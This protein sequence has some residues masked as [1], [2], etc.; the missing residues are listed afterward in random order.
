ML[1]QFVRTLLSPS[2]KFGN[3]TALP[4]WYS[5]AISKAKSHQGVSL[6]LVFVSSERWACSF[7]A[8]RSLMLPSRILPPLLPN[9]L[10]PSNDALT[11]SPRWALPWQPWAEL[12]HDV[13]ALALPIAG[14]A[15]AALRLLPHGRCTHHCAAMGADST[16]A[17]QKGRGCRS[18]FHLRRHG[19]VQSCDGWGRDLV[20][21]TLGAA[22]SSSPSKGL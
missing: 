17:A 18:S 19:C 7:L 6:T 4:V 5:R 1:A 12:S 20:W 9:S 8:S 15:R 22:S 21:A 13:R 10:K 2:R 16:L 11:A 3:V 14:M